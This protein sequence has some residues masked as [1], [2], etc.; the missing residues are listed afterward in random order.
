MQLCF[1]GGL[2][3]IHDDYCRKHLRKTSDHVHS[4]KFPQ[5]T[6]RILITHVDDCTEW[7][8]LLDFHRNPIDN[9]AGR[10]INV[11]VQL[12]S[13][14]IWAYTVDTPGLVW[15]VGAEIIAEMCKCADST[16]ILTPQPF[17][18]KSENAVKEQVWMEKQTIP[19]KDCEEVILQ[20]TDDCWF[21]N[22]YWCT[23]SSN[24]AVLAQQHLTKDCALFRF[25]S[26]CKNI[27]KGNKCYLNG[28]SLLNIQRTSS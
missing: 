7:D 24:I 26:L 16:V 5:Y 3:C 13:E 14:Q 9:I 17:Q 1:W 22:K 12:E 6:H 4:Q 10:I 23:V 18:F 28:E 2:R 25:G 15:S 11:M 8:S 20:N 27:L 21:R 19:L